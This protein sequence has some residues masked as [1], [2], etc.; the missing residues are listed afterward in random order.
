MLIVPE[1][2][3]QAEM[4]IFESIPFSEVII[5]CISCRALLKFFLLRMS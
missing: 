3:A 5:T 2:K 4:F 1:A